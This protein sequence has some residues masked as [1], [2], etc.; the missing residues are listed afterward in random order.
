MHDAHPAVRMAAI[1]AFGLIYREQY[2]EKEA[3]ALLQEPLQD[4]D[5]MVAI[6]AGWA[7]M[8]IDPAFGT[9]CLQK[10]LSDSLPENRRL[11]A[12]AVAKAGSKGLKLAKTAFSTAQ[13]P[14][15][16]V[17]LALGLLGQ[18]EEMAPCCDA[19]Y[20]FLET[21]KRLLM[22]DKKGNPLFEVLAP[23][24]VRHQDQIPN[25]PEAQDQMTRLHMLSLLTLVDD[26]RAQT[27][28]RSF[29]QKKKWGVTGAAAA[30][31]LHEG[32][33]ASLEVVRRLVQDDDGN[34]RL[35][36][37]LVLALLGRDETALIPLQNAYSLADHDQ[38][39]HI[40]EALGRIGNAQSY[41]FLMGVLREPFPVLRV[42]AASSLIQSVNR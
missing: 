33:E 13:D 6:T 14:Y 27:A 32:D 20:T 11:A 5:P 10:W 36:A 12:A 34:V 25:F 4:A 40:L 39:L 28:I 1:N 18:R 9:P 22:M 2:S 19:I 35:Q 41:S 24:Q 37:C 38:K 15:V 42:A 8:L 30:T 21:E 16:K 23:S 31:L 3:K 7:A 29:L 26:A 17:N